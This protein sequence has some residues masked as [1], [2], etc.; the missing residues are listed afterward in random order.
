[1][2]HLQR[3]RTSFERVFLPSLID[4]TIKI[5]TV[6]QYFD[7]DLESLDKELAALKRYAATGNAGWEVR[8]R[9][10]IGHL[11]RITRYEAIAREVERFIESLGLELRG[12]ET[13]DQILAVADQGWGIIC[14]HC[15]L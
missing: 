12:R 6:Q 2:R 14:H 1:M 15:S 8:V 9:D 11:A 3:M 5:R 4:M 10:K 13:L 7:G